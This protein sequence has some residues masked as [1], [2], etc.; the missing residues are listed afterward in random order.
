MLA[1]CIALEGLKGSSVALLSDLS[2]AV[3]VF[4]DCGQGG[5]A[6]GTSWITDLRQF[7]RFPGLGT[8]FLP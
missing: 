2:V 5:G 4:S 8:L 1:D 6:T 7:F 3:S